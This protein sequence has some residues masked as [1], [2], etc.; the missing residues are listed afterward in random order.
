MEVNEMDPNEPNSTRLILNIT[1]TIP[2]FG[3]TF[4][5]ATCFCGW[6]TDVPYLN[7]A[8]EALL[9]HIADS[10]LYP[11]DNPHSLAFYS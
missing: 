11:Q 6:G 1:R 2:H 8:W 3:D 4:Y 5:N 9:T 7:D 10:N